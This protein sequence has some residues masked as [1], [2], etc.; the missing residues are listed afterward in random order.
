MRCA[1]FSFLRIRYGDSGSSG[2]RASMLLIWPMAFI[3]RMNVD[4]VRLSAT[5]LSNLW[6]VVNP[7]PD[8]SDTSFWV[9]PQRVHLLVHVEGVGLLLAALVGD[10]VLGE[11]PQCPED[12][13][14]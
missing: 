3:R 11:A 2:R 9:S 5:P 12:D 4:S 7:M 8:R 13:I 6:M 14:R 1:F 10:A